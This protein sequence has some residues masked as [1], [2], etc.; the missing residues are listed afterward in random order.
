MKRTVFGKRMTAL[1]LAA[2]LPL[3]FT[4][5]MG[6]AEEPQGRGTWPVPNAAGE[7]A[8]DFAEKLSCAGTGIKNS[9][10]SRPGGR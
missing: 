10:F 7:C 4:R 8:K 5:I 3:L 1:A 6:Q 2:I 9:T